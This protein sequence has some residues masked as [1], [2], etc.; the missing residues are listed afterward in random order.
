MVLDVLVLCGLAHLN[1]REPRISGPEIQHLQLLASQVW[2]SGAR[3]EVKVRSPRGW[4]RNV[5]RVGDA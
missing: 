4:V 2:W 3:S 1:P 5:L